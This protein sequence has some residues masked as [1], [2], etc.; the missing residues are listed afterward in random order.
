MA[1]ILTL[2]YIT[3]DLDSKVFSLDDLNSILG[4]LLTNLSD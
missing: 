1:S 2:G 4:A 3:E